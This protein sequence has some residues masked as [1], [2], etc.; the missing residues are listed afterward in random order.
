MICQD[1]LNHPDTPSNRIGGTGACRMCA[2]LRQDRFKAANKTARALYDAL[3][4]QGVPADAE[5]LAAAWR[6][7]GGGRDE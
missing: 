3:V 7:L 6:A 2:K 4:E 5:K 1:P